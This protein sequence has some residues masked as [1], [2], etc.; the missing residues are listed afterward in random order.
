[1]T[2]AALR[3]LAPHTPAPGN[4]AAPG[5]VEAADRRLVAGQLRRVASERGERSAGEAGGVAPGQEELLL[6]RA[7]RH[8]AVPAD[9]R[10]GSPV[11]TQFGVPGQPAGR[12]VAGRPPAF[13]GVGRV[14]HLE[15]EDVPAGR[16]ADGHRRVQDRGD[17]GEEH[18][19][20]RPPGP[21]PAGGGRRPSRRASATRSWWRPAGR[22][23]GGRRRCR[24]PGGSAAAR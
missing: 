7:G 1:M 24:R 21:G 9:A 2:V 5:E 16:A 12:L 18:R 11:S 6:V 17:V 3:P 8:R 22:S 19:L 23:P 10:R 13:E 20:A 14:E 15:A 4:V